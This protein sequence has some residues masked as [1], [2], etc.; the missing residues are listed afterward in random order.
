[1]TRHATTRRTALGVLLA[2]PLAMVVS[3]CEAA[4][5][6][7]RK[8]TLV[9]VASVDRVPPGSAFR[10]MYAD[11]PIVLVNVDGDIRG[12]IAVCT[13]EG[14]PL[15]WNENQHLIRCPCHGGAYDTSGRVVDGPPPLPLTRLETVVS[16]GR[17]WVVERPNDSARS[18]RS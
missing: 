5:N 3:A 12:F 7:F 16:D 17:V 11:Q 6:R 9:A 18:A 1:V 8:R 10:T 2:T 4:A 14:C 13:H 15:G